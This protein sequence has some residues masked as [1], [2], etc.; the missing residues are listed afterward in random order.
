MSGFV[1]RGLCKYAESP[2]LT[3]LVHFSALL[4]G[5]GRDIS[6]EEALF[7]GPTI[8]LGKEGW[9]PTCRRISFSLATMSFGLLGHSTS[10]KQSRNEDSSAAGMSGFARF[11]KVK[12]YFAQTVRYPSAESASYCT[13]KSLSQQHVCGSGSTRE[14]LHEYS[15]RKAVCKMASQVQR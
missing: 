1:F 10:M 2:L 5:C 14:I 13:K 11:G 9:R 12:Y 8:S 6:L 3:L 15:N 7:F 4:E